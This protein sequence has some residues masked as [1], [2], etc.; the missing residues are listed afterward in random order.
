MK[1]LT[2]LAVDPFF[3]WYFGVMGDVLLIV[4]IVTTV[5]G[6]TI[7]GF[8][9]VLWFL[10]AICSYLGMIWVVALRI[11]TR[12]ETKAEEQPQ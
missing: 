4:G 3:M 1:E 6:T 10:L 2:K 7:A 8:T 11:L 12:L 9:P 5:M